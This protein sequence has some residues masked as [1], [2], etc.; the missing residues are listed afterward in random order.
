MVLKVFQ[1]TMDSLVPLV[2]RVNQVLL[3]LVPKVNQACQ[4]VMAT[5]VLLVKKE[6]QV[7]LVLLVI[8]VV[9][10]MCQFLDKKVMLVSRV[11]QVLQV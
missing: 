1:V 10:V 6:T 3:L 9:I 2:K 4:V 8:Q 7:S 11:S 5:L